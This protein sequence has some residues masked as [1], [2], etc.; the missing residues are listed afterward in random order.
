[1]T[2]YVIADV[3]ITNPQ[4]YDE[5]RRH[6]SETLIPYGGRFF[7]CPRWAIRDLGRRLDPRSHCG[8]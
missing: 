8:D 4:A 7:Y 5:Y 6:T 2:A 1:M 3:T